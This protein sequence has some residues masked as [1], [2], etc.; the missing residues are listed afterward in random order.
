MYE[1]QTGFVKCTRE[2][3]GRCGVARCGVK[4]VAVVSLGSRG[5]WSHRVAVQWEWHD[6]WRYRARGDGDRGRWARCRGQHGAAAGGAPSAPAPF[7]PPRLLAHC[8][9]A[10]R[11]FTNASYRHESWRAVRCY[12]TAHRARHVNFC[13]DLCIDLNVTGRAS[14]S[15]RLWIFIHEQLLWCL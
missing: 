7:L 14:V 15:L 2:R 4:A 6:R 13:V 10:R 8:V 12:D 11:A 5:N 3:Y 1:K 9:A